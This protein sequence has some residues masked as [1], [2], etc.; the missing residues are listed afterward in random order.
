M[1]MIMASLQKMRKQDEFTKLRK[2]HLQ[3]QKQN[4]Q[5]TENTKQS[6]FQTATGQNSS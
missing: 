6:S 1:D 5:N 3:Q 4:N 2:E